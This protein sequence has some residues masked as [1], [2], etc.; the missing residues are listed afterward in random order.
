MF[1]YDLV[2]EFIEMNYPNP[3]DRHSPC[4]GKDSYLEVEEFT[5]Q[6]GYT[7]TRRKRAKKD[8]KG[9]VFDHQGEKEED[10]SQVPF[11]AAEAWRSV[12]PELAAA[13]REV[14]DAQPCP[15]DPCGRPLPNSYLLPGPTHDSY[16]P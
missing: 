12:C 2:Y 13:V 1:V 6:G 8:S 7:L 16:H 9:E 4:P 5:L 3:N 14:W 11:R 15:S 10:L